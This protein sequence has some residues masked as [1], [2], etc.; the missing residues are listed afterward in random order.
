MQKLDVL[1][2]IIYFRVLDYTFASW[3]SALDRCI[4]YVA[5]QL[6]PV[7]RPKVILAGT[8]GLG[9]IGNCIQLLTRVHL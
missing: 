9:V 7:V 6:Q 2:I 1:K 8:L 4:Y 5:R 3:G